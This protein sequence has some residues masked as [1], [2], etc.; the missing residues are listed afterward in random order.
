MQAYVCF[1]EIYSLKTL[2]LYYLFSNPGIKQYLWSRDDTVISPFIF[3][4]HVIILTSLCA[5]H[6]QN[7]PFVYITYFQI[8]VSSDIYGHV[9][10]LSFHS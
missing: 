7:A 6:L 3:R 8:P 10:V 5:L 1:G 4:D 2:C 9:T